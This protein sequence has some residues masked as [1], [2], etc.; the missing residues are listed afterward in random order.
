MS[1]TP[2]RLPQD[3]HHHN[4][5]SSTP[6]VREEPQERIPRKRC[7][8]GSS[9]APLSI[10]LS[11]LVLSPSSIGPLPHHH[12]TPVGGWVAAED[13]DSMNTSDIEIEAIEGRLR[14][15]RIR[16]ARQIAVECSLLRSEGCSA[17]SPGQE[18][19]LS[20]PSHSSIQERSPD[21]P[22]S[23]D[24]S[25]ARSSSPRCR[26][27]DGMLLR[28]PDL[29]PLPQPSSPHIASSR[30]S[31]ISLSPPLRG[32]VGGCRQAH[33]PPRRRSPSRTGE[34]LEQLVAHRVSPSSP[35]G[36]CS[37]QGMRTLDECT[38]LVS[39]ALGL[40]CEE[41]LSSQSLVTSSTQTPK[42]RSR[43]RSMKRGQLAVTKGYRN[44]LLGPLGTS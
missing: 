3:R 32:M 16:K 31:M 28:L 37:P 18:I 40:R 26:V 15:L 38:K 36:P 19:D 39:S 34:Q 35:R 41:R 14:E 17:R 27:C 43:S 2:P 29:H 4:R 7:R 10:D 20:S 33:R 6:F 5:P 23:P 22:C 24:R 9:D 8:G 12:H 13:V 30:V 21:S 11:R 1:N 44:L 42:R 25:P